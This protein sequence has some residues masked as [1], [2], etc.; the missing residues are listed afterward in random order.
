MSFFYIIKDFYIAIYHKCIYNNYITLRFF[1]QT[2]G[3]YI[4]IS[5]SDFLLNTNFTIL[6]VSYLSL[7]LC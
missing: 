4:C 1:I 2:G 5:L 3:T 6:L 7:V